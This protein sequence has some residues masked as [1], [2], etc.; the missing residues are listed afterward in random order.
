MSPS[1]V[2]L[3]ARLY[4]SLPYCYIMFALF[5][6]FLHIND[7][8]KRI[9][10]L[11][12]PQQS[13]LR[14]HLYPSER[15]ERAIFGVFNSFTVKKANFFTINVKF[16][17]I[18]S[19][20]S[21]GMFVQ[22]IPP[23]IKVGGYIPPPPSPR[24]LRQCYVYSQVN[25]VFTSNQ[26]SSQQLVCIFI[27]FCQTAPPRTPFPFIEDCTNLGDRTVENC[28]LLVT[29]AVNLTCSVLGYYP[30]ITLYFRHN[31]MRLDS[32]QT[33]EWNNT[34]GSKNKEITSTAKASDA[35]Y[36]CVA[37][38]I[39]GL[40]DQE[41]V[42]SIFLHVAPDGSTS[43]DT[44]AVMSTERSGSKR[45]WTKGRYFNV[46]NSLHGVLHLKYSYIQCSSVMVYCRKKRQ[47]HDDW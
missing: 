17:V 14:R 16:K 24:D 3:V 27:F 41:Q 45:N 39:P 43:Q 15:S 6:T 28:S 32:V 11:A 21:G 35:P 23:P 2:L 34:D 37:E 13:S 19:S 36:T 4:F 7:V 31:S 5:Y 40:R 8:K 1:L 33:R 38:D 46:L 26:Y 42:A 29:N 9:H 18:L 25:I 20:K 44:T 10:V 22:A 12:K 47:N 30:Y